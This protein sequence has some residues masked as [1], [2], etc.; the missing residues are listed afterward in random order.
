[1]SQ[2]GVTTTMALVEYKGVTT[3]T[4]IPVAAAAASGAG[5]GGNALASLDTANVSAEEVGQIIHHLQEE[6]KIIK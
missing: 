2:L 1:M 6:I 4:S 3:S 5:Q